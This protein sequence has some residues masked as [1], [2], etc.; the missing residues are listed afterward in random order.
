MC[1]LKAAFL[2]LD[3]LWSRTKGRKHEKKKTNTC[4]QTHWVK[5]CRKAQGGV[6]MRNDPAAFKCWTVPS[7]STCG[8]RRERDGASRPTRGDA[9][10]AFTVVGSPKPPGLTQPARSHISESAASSLCWEI[11]FLTLFGQK[12]SS[13]RNVLWHYCSIGGVETRNPSINTPQ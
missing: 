6:Q 3:I 2:K 10:G 11:K 7:W 8:A 4:K 5:W 9:A 13:R 1:F 12:T